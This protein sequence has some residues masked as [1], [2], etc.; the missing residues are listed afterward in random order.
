LSKL[1]P[2]TEVKFEDINKYKIEDCVY[3]FA[4]G[5]PANTGGDNYSML[6]LWV[7]IIEN[8]INVIVK[9][10]IYSKNGIESLTDVIKDKLREHFIEETYLEVNGVGVAS[11]L[12]LKKE[13]ENHT[14][15]KPFTTTEN[16]EAKILSNYEFIKK[17]FI[18]DS[19]YKSNN[20]H[21][22]F[23]THLTGYSKEGDNKHKLDAIDNASMVAKVLKVKYKKILYG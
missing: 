7:Y 10:I 17:Y 1:I 21:N 19:G 12:L 13:I 16:K 11:Y 20:E 14:T 5:D 18:F 4:I 15:I 23:I 8:K 22:Q 9:D 6:F 3:K 2:I